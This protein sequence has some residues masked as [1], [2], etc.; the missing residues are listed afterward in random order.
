MHGFVL[1]RTPVFSP[2]TQPQIFSRERPLEAIF[3]KLTMPSAGGEARLQQVAPAHAWDMAAMSMSWFHR[4]PSYLAREAADGSSG[5][6]MPSI[7][8]SRCL[9]GATAAQVRASPSFGG[10]ARLGSGVGASPEIEDT[11]GK[12]GRGEVGTAA[13]WMSDAVG[14][15][16]SS[17]LRSNTKAHANLP[18][19]PE[20]LHVRYPCLR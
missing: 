11:Q 5:V 3:N 19:G 12:D 2:L 10:R 15:R 6:G 4:S 16:A 13:T 18:E 17:L 8:D 7:H 20:I 1:A 14:C 9:F